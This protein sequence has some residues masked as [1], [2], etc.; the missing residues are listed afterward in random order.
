MAQTGQKIFA[1]GRFWGVPTTSNPTPSPFGL[2]QDIAIDFKRDLKKLYGLNQF[3]ADAA[4]GPMSITGK[5]S[6]GTIA[7]RMVNNLLLG[8]SLSTGQLPWIAEESATIAGT[9]LGNGS[10]TVANAAGF[11]TDLGVKGSTSGIPF[12]RVSTGSIT[13]SQQYSVSTA[14]V[15]S[16]SSLEGNVAMKASYLYTT[17]GGQTVSMTNQ[18]MGKIG[19]FAAT[20]A[21]LWNNE[22]ATLQLNKCMASDYGIATKIDDYTKP[23]FGFEAFADD[24]DILGT[25][26]FAELS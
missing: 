4:S 16:F 2:A 25:Y 14:G 26:S 17:T 24:S 7:G 11:Q 21:F 19:E 15:Y 22:K 23:T 13:S 8:G 3:P 1:A 6:M 20:A 18:P 9:T 12:T 10:F 5:V